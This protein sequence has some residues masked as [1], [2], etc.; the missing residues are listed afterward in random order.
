M[1]TSLRRGMLVTSAR[2]RGSARGRHR[3]SRRRLAR[4]SDDRRGAPL[5]ASRTPI[6]R[7][8]NVRRRAGVAE[9]VA[10]DPRRR[11]PDRGDDR[12]VGARTNVRT[13]LRGGA[14]EIAGER[15]PRGGARSSRDARGTVREGESGRDVRARGDRGRRTRRR[16]RVMRRL[17]SSPC[18][19]VSIRFGRALELAHA[20]VCRGTSTSSSSV[21]RVCA[22]RRALE[23][24]SA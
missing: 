4:G 18:V 8:A 11:V 1:I 5:L 16:S 6:V 9:R 24:R 12:A 13:L 21:R 7:R 10:R 15:F 22:H 2:A 20:S 3:A 17:S 19:G 14:R 23:A